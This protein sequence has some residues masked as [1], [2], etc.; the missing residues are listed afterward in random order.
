MAQQGWQPGQPLELKPTIITAGRRNTYWGGEG[1]GYVGS[2]DGWGPS[3]RATS[4]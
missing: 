3:R 2:G 4:R 1:G